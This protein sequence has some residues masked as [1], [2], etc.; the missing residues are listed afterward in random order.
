MLNN[1]WLSNFDNIVGEQLTPLWI[2]FLV[3]NSAHKLFIS[4]SNVAIPSTSV[5]HSLKTVQKFVVASESREFARIS[6]S[7]FSNFFMYAAS[8]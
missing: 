2:L 5:H 3:I 4:S 1:G 8:A 6:S 7:L